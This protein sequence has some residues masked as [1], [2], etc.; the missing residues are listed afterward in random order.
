MQVSLFVESFPKLRGNFGFVV[1][2][3]PPPTPNPVPDFLSPA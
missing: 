2:V 1:V 3:S